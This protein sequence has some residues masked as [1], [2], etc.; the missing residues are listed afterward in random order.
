MTREAGSRF[1]KIRKEEPCDREARLKTM[2]KPEIGSKSVAGLARFLKTER[3]SREDSHDR[4]N[5]I[6]EQ[7]R[8]AKMR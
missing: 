8:K 3:V 7:D 4:I 6:C 5:Q 1:A 2:S